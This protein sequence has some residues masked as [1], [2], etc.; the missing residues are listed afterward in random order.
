VQHRFA[1]ELP[2]PRQRQVRYLVQERLPS[3][4]RARLTWL[5]VDTVLI[6]AYAASALLLLRSV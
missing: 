3:R 6:L 1:S 5:V 4:L 2:R